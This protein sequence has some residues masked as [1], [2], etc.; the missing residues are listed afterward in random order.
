MNIIYFLMNSR[1]LTNATPSI[2]AVLDNTWLAY[3]GGTPTIWLTRVG[4]TTQPRSVF[5]YTTLSFLCVLF[6]HCITLSLSLSSGVFLHIVAPSIQ[7]LSF[8]I[9]SLSGL[10]SSLIALPS[11]FPGLFFFFFK[12]SLSL[13]LRS[14]LSHCISAYLSLLLFRSAL[15]SH[16][17]SPSLSQGLLF[18][19]CIS[20]SLSLKYV[21]LSRISVSLAF[22][23][24]LSHCI[25]IFF[26]RFSGLFFSHCNSP[27]LSPGLFFSN[28]ISLSLSQ[29]CSPLS[30]FCLSLSSVLSHCISI[31]S[32]A[33]QVC[34]SLIVIP[35]P[36]LQVC[37]FL[38]VFLSLS[39]SLSQVCSPLSYFCLS[40]AFTSV[41]SH[42]ISIFFSRFSGL[43]FSHCNSPPSLQVCSFSN[44]ISL[45]LSQVCSPLSFLCLSLLSS[46]LS[47]C[48]SIFFSR[49][50]GL[51][52]SHCNSPSLSPGLFFSNCISLS[53][54]L[55]CS[56]L[57]FSFS[58]THTDRE[59]YLCM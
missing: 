29:V 24:V 5:F 32:L 31:F 51:F 53:V 59:T 46:V 48:I 49:F 50:S 57:S 28:C 43:F 58:L 1:K 18:S 25:S 39:L 52:F 6:S 14:L 35:P 11:L 21:L 38:I 4:L 20:L 55:V 54:S 30:Y 17:N 56:P 33:F 36:S 15:I 13:S 34:S 27:S 2:L 16:C 8:L 26:S 22:T 9:V 7:L 23:S 10:F 37:S 41:L 40:L 42:C 45:S 3:Q 19:N 44:C 12:F 47:H